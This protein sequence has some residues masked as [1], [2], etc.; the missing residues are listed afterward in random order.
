MG[1]EVLGK[2]EDQRTARAVGPSD[3]GVSLDAERLRFRL[4]SIRVG[5]AMTMIVALGT[6][7]YALATP[8]H[9][10]RLALE[11]VIA[12]G[13]LTAPTV[14][15]LPRERIIQSRWR[16]PFFVLWSTALIATIAAAAALDGGTGSP[17]RSLFVLPLMFAAL[18]YPPRYVLAVAL[19]SLAGY[20]TVALISA[21]HTPETAFIAFALGCAA[22]LSTWQARIHHRQD[23]R[24]AESARALRE[25]ESVSRR[26]A[27]QQEQVARFGQLA[28]ARSRIDDLMEL[29]VTSVQRTL[30]VEMAAILEY[31]PEEKS[32]LVRSGAGFPDGTVGETTVPG[33]LGSQAGYTLLTGHPVIVE[34]WAEET[35]FAISEVLRRAGARSGVTLPIRGHGEPFGVFGAQSTMAGRFGTH[36]VNFLQAISNILAHELERREAEERARRRALHDPLTGLPNRALF[37]DRLGRA[38]AESERHASSVAV[39]FIDVDH[40]KVIND[41]VGHAAGDE[42][43]KQVAPR[44]K[45]AVR[46]ADTIARFGGDE[47]GVLLAEVADERTAIRVAERIATMLATPFQIGGREHFIGVSTGIVLGGS[48]RD[49]DELIR[50]ADTAMYSAKRRGRGRY[51]LF[52]HDMRARVRELI[53]VDNELRTA[54]ERSDLRLSYQPVVDLRSGKVIGAEALVRWQHP[55]RGLLMPDQ[56]IGVA[57]ETGLIRPLGGWVLENACRD[58]AE[59]QSVDADS[60]PVQL[61]VNV[62][63]RQLT[64]DFADLVEL[65]L[66]H[67]AIQPACLSLELIE[68]VLIEDDPVVREALARL[69]A[70]GVGLALDDFGTGYSSLGY[71]KRL[72]FRTIKLDR[73]FVQHIKPGGVDEAIVSAVIKLGKALGLEVVAEG[74]ET[75][76][77]LEI[78]SALGCQLVQG[79]HF[80]P[81]LSPPDFVELLA[82]GLAPAAQPA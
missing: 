52:D 7:A 27:Q 77:Q 26:R 5:V 61:S 22:V 51:E 18:S 45:Q 49:P 63:V 42:L 12:A 68:G 80:S 81:P 1:D 57:E 58:A 29:A 16:E 46:G 44:L 55:E 24:L 64:P 32:F 48:G 17:L 9:D 25:S 34:D 35:R 39:L 56:F 47:F 33:G 82:T 54:I 36:E 65:T 15:L 21:T 2:E 67:S 8:D 41:S 69:D 31:R 59:W 79:H 28:L 78:V 14:L 4:A 53:T 6:E 37:A 40:F 20:G 62:S 50:D 71:L 23:R 13:L 66:D 74:V 11:L 72:S 60:R 73:S 75:K 10:S 3:S 43:L 30:G 70:I 76:Q 38:L 19:I